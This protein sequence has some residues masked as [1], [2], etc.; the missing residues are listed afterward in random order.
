MAHDKKAI[1][2]KLRLVLPT[3]PGRAMLV[4]DPG[5]TVIVAGIEAI[6]A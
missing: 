6:R 1:G 4:E 2:G 3:G 5:R